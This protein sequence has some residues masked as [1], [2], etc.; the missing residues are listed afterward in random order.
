MATIHYDKCP[1]CDSKQLENYITATDWGLTGESFN[2]E[3]CISCSFALTQDAPDAESIVKYYHHDD[4]VSHSDTT[5]GL[6]FKV[7]HAVRDFM[8]NKKR[9]WVEQN[10]TKGI[11]LDIGSGT[12]YFLNN[13][14]NNNWQVNGFEPEAAAR[15]VA[16]NNF[17]IELS[18]NLD[19]IINAEQK[20]DAITMWH[21]LEHVHTLNDYFVY[22]K[23]ML[24]QDGAVFIAVPNYTSKDAK[25]YMEK[26]AALDLPK[27]L[28][29]F[30]PE[31]LKSL[32]EK[33]GFQLTKK[34]A[35]PFDAFYIALLSEKGFFGKLRAIIIGK[36]SFF[37]S[38]FNVDNASSILYVLKNKK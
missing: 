28:W 9:N 26:W 25:F 17:G 14:K 24:K 18:N 5:E 32:A 12:G 11:V 20:Y 29:H 16:K 3:K 27:H 31:S 21:V 34:H 19:S 37:S 38:L 4:Y 1:V 36:Y 6:F 8:L 2:I 15:K 13:M 7:Y 33:H 10:T 22:F 35:L 30:S 23:T